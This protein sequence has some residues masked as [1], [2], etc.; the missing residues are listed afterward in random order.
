MP[1]GKSSENY[2]TFLLST[3]MRLLLK[4]FQPLNKA[5]F[6]NNSVFLISHANSK[7]LGKWNYHISLFSRKLAASG[8]RLQ[9]QR[10]EGRSPNRQRFVFFSITHEEIFFSE[11]LEWTIV[12]LLSLI[13]HGTSKLQVCLGALVLCDIVFPRYVCLCLFAIFFALI[14]LLVPHQ[15]SHTP[16]DLSNTPPF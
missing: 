3:Q 2:S 4:I 9:E 10:R 13:L 5:Y 7:N 12:S 14:N 16:S 11:T 6:I 1:L 15:P 8:R